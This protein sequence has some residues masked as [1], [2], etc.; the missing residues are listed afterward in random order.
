MTRSHALL[1]QAFWLSSLSNAH[2]SDCHKSYSE[3]CGCHNSVPKKLKILRTIL[4]NILRSAHSLKLSVVL[5]Y[6][7]TVC[8]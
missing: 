1:I 5:L 2:Q 6:E 8:P 3:Y 4:M 7:M